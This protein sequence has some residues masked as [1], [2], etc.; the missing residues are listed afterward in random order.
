MIRAACFER[1]LATKNP[2]PTAYVLQ[3][4]C[5]DF[6]GF[7]THPNYELAISF[8]RNLPKCKSEVLKASTPGARSLDLSP[9][10]Q[11]STLNCTTTL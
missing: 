7:C 8:S 11:I 9:Y 4:H 10:A 2:T 5:T 6:S 1:T 3:P